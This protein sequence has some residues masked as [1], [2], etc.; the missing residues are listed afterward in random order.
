MAEELRNAAFVLPRVMIS[1]VLLNSLMMFVMCLT[2]SYCVGSDLTAGKHAAFW[3]CL[4][5]I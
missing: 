1:S 2:I 4:Y 5:G 3:V